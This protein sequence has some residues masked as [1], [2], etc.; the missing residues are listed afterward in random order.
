MG[1]VVAEEDD[2]LE[3]EPRAGRFSKGPLRQYMGR[4]S[5]VREGAAKG[6]CVLRYFLKGCTSVTPMRFR[7]V[8]WT[9]GVGSV[10]ALTSPGQGLGTAVSTQG[11]VIV[12]FFAQVVTYAQHAI[13]EY[14]G[15]GPI[16]IDPSAPTHRG[17]WLGR[18]ILHLLGLRLPPQFLPRRHG[19]GCLA[20]TLC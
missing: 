4:L 20:L 1:E 16:A 12:L 8:K 6:A 18:R 2:G 11:H 5:V 3:V 10:R 15:T 7:P 19:H 14:V 13:S 9:L 17:A